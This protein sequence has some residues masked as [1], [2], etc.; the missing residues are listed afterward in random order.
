MAVAERS[1]RDLFSTCNAREW[2]VMADMETSYAAFVEDCRQ[3]RAHITGLIEA[4]EA[5]GLQVIPAFAS[6]SPDA[7]DPDCISKR[8]DFD[9]CTG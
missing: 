5:K 7:G 6:D 8:C 2:N 4:L 1:G 9:K 3:E